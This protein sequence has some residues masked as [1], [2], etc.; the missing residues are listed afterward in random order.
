MHFFHETIMD[1]SIKML[2]F[3]ET[4]HNKVDI[5][6]VSWIHMSILGGPTLNQSH[7]TTTL[8]DNFYMTGVCERYAP[9]IPAPLGGLIGLRP[10]AKNKQ[11]KLKFIRWTA[12]GVYN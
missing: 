6:C 7:P 10:I 11:N 3:I 4:F 1:D 12:V 2:F 9:L 8:Y 5:K